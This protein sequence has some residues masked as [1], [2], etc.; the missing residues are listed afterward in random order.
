METL[1]QFLYFIKHRV[2]IS[3]ISNLSFT[4]GAIRF[5]RA[6]RIHLTRN[7]CYSFVK[8]STD[9]NASRVSEW[10]RLVK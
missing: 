10:R 4:E 2:R 6:F 3:N 9:C 8:M 1:N 5:R 7:M